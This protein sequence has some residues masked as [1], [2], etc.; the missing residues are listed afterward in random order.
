MT[1]KDSSII[2]QLLHS[3]SGFALVVFLA[4]TTFFLVAENTSHVLGV[5]PYG[6]VALCLVMHLFMHR[7]HGNHGG[8]HK[9]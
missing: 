4:I 7:E 6:L 1:N 3:K 5:L 8:Q 2:G 9:H